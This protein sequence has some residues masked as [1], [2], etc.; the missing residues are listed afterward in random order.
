MPKQTAENLSEYYNCIGCGQCCHFF[1][2]VINP[3]KLLIDNKDIKTAFKNELAV[4]MSDV[5]QCSVKVNTTCK[6]LDKITGKCTIYETRPDVC[7]NHFC[8]RYPKIDEENE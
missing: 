6:H 4:E 2:M 3:K 5:V 8:Q 7:R 1:E